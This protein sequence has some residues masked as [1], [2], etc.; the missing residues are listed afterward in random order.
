[1]EIISNTIILILSAL[2]LISLIVAIHELGHF[3]VARYFGVKVITFKIGFGKTLYSRFDS[4]GTEF[5]IGLI[6][7]GGYVQM[8]GESGYIEGSSDKNIGIGNSFSNASAG[9]RAM[10]AAAGPIANFILAIFIYT[11]ILLIG[12]KDLAPIVGEVEE[13]SLA[14][15]MG[16][17]I[18][19]K[20]VSIDDQSISNFSD[21]N[22]SLV[23][24]I[25]ESDEIK[26]SFL[27]KEKGIIIIESF[28]LNN[29]LL[30]SKNPL[31]DF[32]ISPYIPAIISSVIPDTAAFKAG[33]LEKD[34]II[35]IN[36]AE[37]LVWG[38]LVKS[39]N[40]NKGQEVLIRVERE[41]QIITLLTFIDS[42]LVEDK[43]SI[44]FGTYKGRLGIT[45]ISS[46][47]DLPDHLTIYKQ[48]NFFSSLYQA[49][50][51]T[52]NY[53]ILILDSIVNM[54]VGKVSMDNIGGPIQISILAG[55]AA[56]AG[57]ISFLSLMAFL[58]INLGLINLLPIPILDGGQLLLIAIE[59]IKGSPISENFLEY[60]FKFSL[61]FI[62][63]I[64]I[65]TIF[66]D[67]MRVI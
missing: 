8:L 4:K 44:D 52:Y 42:I 10:I 35:G 43:S 51:K 16:L 26:I 18:G 41:N 56:K 11:F 40:K 27:E 23:S 13:G 46:I 30:D 37:I 2:S 1:M 66:N 59:K 28:K 19:D 65:F 62:G 17:S 31:K 63:S 47:D 45:R 36:D 67:L 25:G 9:A 5:A 7:L 12:V 39:I 57:L 55:S 34:N 15:D 33:L 29:T 60:A 48:L 50:I 3:L 21:I 32:G 61:L 49:S 22:L 53:S 20:I 6:P 58:S 54:F 38:D 14:D 24:R 64:M